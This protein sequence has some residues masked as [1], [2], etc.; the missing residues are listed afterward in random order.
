LLALPFHFLLGALPLAQWRVS[1]E[2]AAYLLDLVPITGEQCVLDELALQALFGAVGQLP[3]LAFLG[4]FSFLATFLTSS[5]LRQLHDR[6]S[7]AMY[8]L[9]HLGT[10]LL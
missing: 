5:D 1:L 10:Q 4:L 9:L 3:L 8:G 2:V 6:P 7:D